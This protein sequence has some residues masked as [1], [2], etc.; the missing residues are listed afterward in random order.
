ESSTISDHLSRFY[1]S[2]NWQVR[3]AVFRHLDNKWGPHSVDRGWI[4]GTEAFDALK[5]YWA[6]DVKWTVPQPILALAC[7]NKLVAEKATCTL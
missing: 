1:D 6:L 2:D 7:I 3:T 4:P 5:Q